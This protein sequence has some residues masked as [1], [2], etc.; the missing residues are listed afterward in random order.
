MT[1]LSKE[2]KENIIVGGYLKDKDRKI[3]PECVEHDMDKEDLDWIASVCKENN[4]NR[5]IESCEMHKLKQKEDKIQEDKRIE[6]NKKN[7]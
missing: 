3:C 2:D 6:A 5:D 7:D 1:K 4:V